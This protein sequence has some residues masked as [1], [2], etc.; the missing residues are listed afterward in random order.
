MATSTIV[1]SSHAAGGGVLHKNVLSERGETNVLQ[2]RFVF[3]VLVL[4]L[5]VCLSVC[6]CVAL[7]VDK[8]AIAR[9]H[10]RLYSPKDGAFKYEL[11]FIERKDK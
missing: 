9:Q 7:I 3:F 4:V 6:V 5:S 11:D 10:Q 8:T 1:S 2:D